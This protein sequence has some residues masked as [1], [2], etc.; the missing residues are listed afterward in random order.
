MTGV[1]E[2]FYPLWFFGGLLGGASGYAVVGICVVHFLSEAKW[3]MVVGTILRRNVTRQSINHRRPGRVEVFYEYEFNGERWMGRAV[4]FRDFFWGSIG[5]YTKPPCVIPGP[6]K[7]VNIYIFSGN[8]GVSFLH[9]RKPGLAWHLLSFS[10][11]FLV[12]FLSIFALRSASHMQFVVFVVGVVSSFILPVVDLY[13][14]KTVISKRINSL[15][16]R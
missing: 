10:M 1:G 3:Y 4:G 9:L 7:P 5:R 15:E 6:Q 11:L 13:S 14:S 8:P 16:S 12:S 2:S